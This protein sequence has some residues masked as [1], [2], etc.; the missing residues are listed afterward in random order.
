[1]LNVKFRKLQKTA[2]VSVL[3]V[4]WID[5]RHLKAQ[6]EKR[7]LF[8]LLCAFALPVTANRCS[9]N[10]WTMETPD[11]VMGREGKLV[12]LYCKFAHPNREYKGNINII[13]SEKQTQNIFFKYK[14]YLS[15][16]TYKNEIVDNV[17][18]RYRPMGDPRKNDA[19]IIINQLRTTDTNKIL[20]CR[21]ELTGQAGKFGCPHGQIKIPG[22]E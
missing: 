9:I 2:G 8:I 4:Q 20:N 6:R 3:L 7:M 19:S 16:G 17:G 22:E 10:G 14:N 13:W 5:L 15:S 18:D 21:V 1:M 11:E 12:V